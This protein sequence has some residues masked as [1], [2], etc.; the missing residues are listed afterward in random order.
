MAD[1]HTTF[2]IK[3]QI[4]GLEKVQGLKN[5]VRGLANSAKPAASEIT[6]LRIAAQQLAT[7][8]NS[9]TKQIKAAI[10]T[11]EV[12]QA[13]VS[14]T[15]QKYKEL[16]ADIDRARARLA[17]LNATAKTGGGFMAGAKAA[18]PTALAAASASF[19]PSSAQF[20]AFA[21]YQAGG[22]KGGLAGGAIGLGLA[23]A[24]GIGNQIKESA[25]YAAQISR[26]EIALRAVTKTGR[27]YA[28]SQEI[29]QRAS[30][31]LNVPIDV[32]TKQFTQLSASVLGSN[33]TIED[34]ETVFRGVSEAIKATGG[35]AEDIQSGIRA[36]SQIF[37]KGKVSAE[38]LQGQLGERLAGAVVKF[39]KANNSTLEQ[40][41]KD[42]RDG[43]VGLDKIMKFAEQLRVEHKQGALDMAASQE[44][45][46]ERMKVALKDLQNSFGQFF[47]PVGAGFQNII[48]WIARMTEKLIGAADEI[49]LKRLEDQLAD[50]KL[51]LAS[52]FDMG[53]PS[54]GI[55]GAIPKQS[56][57]SKTALEGLIK[58]V[59]DQINAIK[60]V[61][62]ET[63]KVTEKTKNMGDTA[64]EIWDAMKNGA[65]TYAESI[66]SMAEEIGDLTQD[67]FK[68][69]EDQLVSFISTGKLNFKEFVSSILEEMTRIMVRQT[70]MKP[71]TDWFSTLSFAANA[72]GNVYGSN[73]IVPFA[74]GGVVNSPTLFPFKNG[75]GL[76]G[77][78]GPEAIMPLKRGSDGRLGVEAAM[79]RYSPASGVG[80]NN[81]TVNY[82]GDVLQFN[83]ED[84]VRKSDVGGII[85]A[86]ANAGE[87]RTMKS[88]KNSR[89]Q[90]AMIGL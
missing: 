88:L 54:T 69:M 70:I 76:M 19:L 86:A 43:T 35:N 41:Q 44:E 25:Q 78:A 50:L 30:K 68:K 56:D 9:S 37:G 7:A 34:A 73:G 1:P 58:T 27:N 42:L 12:L 51:E 81:V 18:A 22:L 36:M 17:A 87:S 59:E 75:T 80:N 10:T 61:G 8:N 48:T 79:D 16:T 5:A 6:Q 21:G 47:K 71:F 63:D 4:E 52:G 38:E 53:G 74:Y 57:K 89:S 23:G 60:G 67:V 77:E 2:K 31:E 33:G 85:N 40:L 20:G 65:K 62:E 29:I 83:N 39:A 3:A 49:K 14:T 11:F 24:V 45:A 26:L 32:A 46:G 66:K 84:Y 15:S 64:K 13:N 28:K 82:E 72:K 55:L 90:R